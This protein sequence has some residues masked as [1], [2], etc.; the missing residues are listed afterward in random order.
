MR[1]E[2]KRQNILLCEK[3]LTKA[4][5]Y[6]LV[7][8]QIR[9]DLFENQYMSPG[10]IITVSTLHRDWCF[11]KPL[12]SYDTPFLYG[13]EEIL[14]Q[15]PDSKA[16]TQGRT[17]RKRL[18]RKWKRYVS[19]MVREWWA[20]PRRKTQILYGLNRLHVSTPAHCKIK[21]RLLRS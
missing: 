4:K 17:T 14:F 21:K 15:T 1:S 5:E 16:A 19:G 13:R 20:K 10:L 3:K 8:G 7:M 6:T 12:F 18:P 9:Q 11:E 2:N